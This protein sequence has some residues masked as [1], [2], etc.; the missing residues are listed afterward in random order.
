MQRKSSLVWNTQVETRPKWDIKGRQ[1]GAVLCQGVE[2]RT[3]SSYLTLW[4][5]GELSILSPENLTIPT[6]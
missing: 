4:Y 2:A 6:S 3:M 1:V 5:P